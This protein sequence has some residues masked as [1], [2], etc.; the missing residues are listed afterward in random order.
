LTRWSVLVMSSVAALGALTAVVRGRPWSARDTAVARAFVACVDLQV[1]LGLSLYFEV[2][3]LARA[4]RSV[5]AS[6]GFLAL[7]AE[8]ELRFFGLVHP[9]LALLGACVAHAG[10]VAA[11]RTDRGCERHRRLGAAAA[12]ALATFLA[13]IPWPC[14][15]P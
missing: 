15:G 5:W 1:L 10:W 11:R 8:R 14:L 9:A 12:V 7:W 6:E 2:S 3:P 13:L 4:A